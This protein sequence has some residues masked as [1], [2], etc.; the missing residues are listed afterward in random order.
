MDMQMP[1]LDGCQATTRLRDEGY[2]LPI[3]A[4]TANALREDR[5]RCLAAG[6]NDFAVK[7]IDRAVLLATV[8]RWAEVGQPAAATP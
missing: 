3:I 8:A 4:L 7:P 1:V 6:C 5:D 2:P